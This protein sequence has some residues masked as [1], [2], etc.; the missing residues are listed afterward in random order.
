MCTLSP[1]RPGIMYNLFP[2]TSINS[3]VKICGFQWEKGLNCKRPTDIMNLIWCEWK[4][5]VALMAECTI[6][7]LTLVNWCHF[8]LCVLWGLSTM[9]VPLA[10]WESGSGVGRRRY[11]NLSSAFLHNVEMPVSA[12]CPSALSSSSFGGGSR[13][14]F[15]EGLV[16]YVI[17][18]LCHAR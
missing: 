5:S 16:I 2:A 17:N 8:S 9:T 14:V 11:A 10:W 7:I 15:Y 4:R 13:A 6:N 1:H 3:Y 18:S 12:P